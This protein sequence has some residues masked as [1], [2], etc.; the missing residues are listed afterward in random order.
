MSQSLE[1]LLNSPYVKA[2]GVRFDQHG[3]ELTGVMSFAP[4]IVGNPLI[5][6]LH[7]GAVGAFMEMTASASLLCAAELE[8]LPKTIDV[9]VDYLRPAAAKDVYARAIIGRLGSRVA[10]V[11]VEAWQDRREAPVATL[12]A[13]FMIKRVDAA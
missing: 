2:M 13:H 7:G 11:R 9:S 8:G 6:A 5:P 4:H 3:D 12:H 10:N 1:R